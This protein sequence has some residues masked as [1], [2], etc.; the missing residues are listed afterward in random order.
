MGTVT[1]NW[2]TVEEW[3]ENYEKHFYQELEAAQY[4]PLARLAEQG[5]QG[6][7]SI[8]DGLKHDCTLTL[9]RGSYRIGMAVARLEVEKKLT[10]ATAQVMPSQYRRTNRVGLTQL[11]E[12]QK[13]EALVLIE[14][15]QTPGVSK[16]KSCIRAARDIKKKHK[17]TIPTGSLLNL[18][19][20]SQCV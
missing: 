18:V 15:Y 4:E 6:V 2:P 7:N 14:K 11:S 8:R 20:K 10:K 9:L 13:M 3:F 19:R 16:R 17:L 1:E 12:E 5:L